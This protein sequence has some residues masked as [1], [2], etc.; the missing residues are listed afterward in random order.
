M[1]TTVFAVALILTAGL[2][3]QVTIPRG[4]VLPVQLNSSLRSDK[5]QAGGKISARIMQDVP[6][7]GGSKI[8]AGS[9]VIGH[10]IAVHTAADG[11]TVALKFDDL[12]ERG[13]HVALITDVTA[14]ASML[15]VSDAQDPE[16]GPDRG[17]SQW[18]WVTDLIGGETDYGGG[19]VMHGSSI[20]GRSVP[21]GVLLHVGSRASE[22]CG[23]DDMDQK[24]R[25]QAFW[26]FSSDAC[27]V[28]GFRNLT[29]IHAGRTAPVGE[30]IF[31]SD[32]SKVN[33]NAGSGMLLRVNS[34]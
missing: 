17:T 32:K 2:S 12:I 29:I 33:I 11:G 21:P 6:L 27:G 18:E 9:K 30:I 22:G 3:A 7:P 24:E 28:Y 10:I 23:S 5:S 25:L 31:H 8:P 26:V 19:P 1:K 20:V 34:E 15:D 4:T 13:H 16:S 14:V